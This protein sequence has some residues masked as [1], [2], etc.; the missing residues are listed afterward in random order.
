MSGTHLNCNAKT[1]VRVL[2]TGGTIEKSYS[3]TEGTLKNRASIIREGLIS[4]LRLPYT[5]LELESLLN[6]DSLDIDDDDRKL[7]AAAIDRTAVQGDPIIVLHGTDTMALTADYCFRQL[8]QPTV[9]VIFTGAMRPMGF[10]GSDA[11]Q[12]FTEALFATQLLTPGFYISFHSRLFQVPGVR[13]NLQ[14]GT[15]EMV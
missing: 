3:E 9:A 14:A 8:G 10:I 5:Q 4:N 12:N 1:V 11:Q 6:K 13:K 7:I 15:F 2:T